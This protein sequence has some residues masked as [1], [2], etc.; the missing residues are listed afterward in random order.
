MARKRKT[1]IKRTASGRPSR[2]A[3]AYTE[4]LEPILTRMR[5]FG[6]SEVDARDQK[7]ST[8]IGRLQLTKVISQAQYDAAQEYLKLYEAFQRAVKSPDALRSSGGGGDQGESPT[9]A[10]WCKGAI[11]RKEAADRAVMDEQCVIANRGRNLFAGLDYLVTRNEEHHHLVGDCRLAL[12]ALVDHFSGSKR[13][14][15]DTAGQI[16]A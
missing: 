14:P 7:A 12:N 5:L 3:D 13:R 11:A 15:V 16:A 10:A 1:G 8:F 9:Y 6:L 2:A 4:N